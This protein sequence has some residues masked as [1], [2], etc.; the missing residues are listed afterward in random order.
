[1]KAFFRQRL[2]VDFDIDDPASED[3]EPFDLDGL[4]SGACGT[5]SSPARPRR[6]TPAC[7]GEALAAAL[8]RIQRRG[9]LAA[10]AFAGVMID[11]LA[12]PMAD[13]FERYAEA[14]AEWPHEAHDEP[15]SHTG[16]PASH[17]RLAARPAQRTSSAG[18]WCWRPAM[19]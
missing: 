16:Q 13:M 5:S 8:A 11:D 19:P 17:R 14:L 12:A 1:V 6:S 4:Q 18:A 9:E 3:H 15:V 2:H 7:R 10:G